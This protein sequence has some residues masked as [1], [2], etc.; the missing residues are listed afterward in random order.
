MNSYDFTIA[1]F[2]NDHQSQY[3]PSGR[4]NNSNDPEFGQEWDFTIN[5]EKELAQQRATLNQLRQK[6]KSPPEDTLFMWVNSD[7]RIN[8][9]RQYKSQLNIF[10]QSRHFQPTRLFAPKTK[11][12]PELLALCFEREAA[13]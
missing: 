11:I 9:L 3:T 7:T 8:N 4:Y 12:S 10:I 13:H 2:P 5:L 6:S 1:D